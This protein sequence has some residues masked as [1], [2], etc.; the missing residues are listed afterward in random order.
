MKRNENGEEEAREIRNKRAD[1]R[2]VNRAKGEF[3]ISTIRIFREAEMIVRSRMTTIPSVLNNNDRDYA[4]T[5]CDKR[6][7]T[8][9]STFE[10]N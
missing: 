6:E 9:A 10:V 7:R 5:N 1:K 3:L 8:A 4:T 2:D